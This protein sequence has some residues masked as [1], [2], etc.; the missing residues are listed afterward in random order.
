MYE[1]SYHN[2]NFIRIWSEKT[3]FFDGWSLFKFNNLGLALG[4]VLKFYT[5]VAKWL[6]LKTRRF[7]ELIPTFVEVTEEKLVRGIIFD[8]PTAAPP[9]PPPQLTWI[10]LS[11]YSASLIS[12]DSAIFLFFTNDFKVTQYNTEMITFL[13]VLIKMFL[14]L[15]SINLS[16]S[17]LHVSPVQYSTRPGSGHIA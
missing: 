13:R 16:Y 11:D 2:L 9:P 14:P 15:W 10:V 1:K 12:R 6:K 5:S 4:M 17:L 7:C 8:H 3:I